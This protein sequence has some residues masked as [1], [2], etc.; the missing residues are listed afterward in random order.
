[1]ILAR[2]IFDKI[3]EEYENEAD[4]NKL[5]ILFELLVD[6]LKIDER[7]D[8]LDATILDYKSDFDEYITLIRQIP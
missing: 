4:E 6:E 3:I 5:I 2:K 8:N 1:M 7:N